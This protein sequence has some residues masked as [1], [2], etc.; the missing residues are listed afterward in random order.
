MKRS[1]GVTLVEVLVSIV[2]LGIGLVGV[3][4]C[5]NAALISNR[6]ASRI[7]LATA[8]AQNAIENMRSSGDLLSS[9]VALGDTQFPAGMLTVTVT[10]FDVQ[11]RLKRVRVNVSWN[12]LRGGVEKVSLDTIIS[13]RMKHVGG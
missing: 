4:N 13:Q 6:R 1:H 7:S 5:L 9:Q 12:G 11:L 2:I 8:I 10:D 3:V